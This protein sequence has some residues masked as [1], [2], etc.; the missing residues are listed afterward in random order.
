MNKLIVA[1]LCTAFASSSFAQKTRYNLTYHPGQIEL[2]DQQKESIKKIST[3]IKPDQ[4]VSIFPLTFDSIRNRLTFS[5]KAKLQAAEVAN[6]AKTLGYEIQGIPANFPTSYKGLSVAV[7]IVLSNPETKQPKPKNS[8]SDL[9]PEKPS[10]FFVIDPNKDT[11]IIGIE[12]TKLMFEKGCL[13]SKQKVKIEL[14]EYYGLDDYIKSGLPTVSNGQMI[15]TGGSIYLNATDKNNEKK[16]VSI[17]PS[18]G[19]GVDFTLGKDDPDMQVFIKDPR[20]PMQ[21]NWILPKQKPQVRKSWQ[22]TE[23]IL[24]ADSTIR[25]KKVF[26]S[27]AEWEAYLKKQKQDAEIKKTTQKKMDSKL[28]VFNLGYINCDKFYQEPMVPLI[29][30]ADKNTTAEYYLVYT[31]VRGVMKGKVFNQRVNFGSVPADREA[32]LIAVSYIDNQTYYFKCNFKAGSSTKPDIV[33]EP[34][35]ETFLNEQLALLK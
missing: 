4:T 27:K 28:K 20:Y 33:L 11:M 21:V 19:V 23:T 34:V 32:Q 35:K 10:Q 5:R 24:N 14:K 17:N 31:D 7:N 26:H 9:F 1:V 18:K 16:R 3:W 8:L 30:L 25:S 15:Q 22:M 12:G 6:Y 13:L 2:N 29:V